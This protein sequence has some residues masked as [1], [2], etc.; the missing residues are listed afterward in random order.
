[1]SRAS[2]AGS[3]RWPLAALAL[4]QVGAGLPSAGYAY[5]RHRHDLA[6]AAVTALFAVLILNVMLTLWLCRLPGVDSRRAPVLTVALLATVG[7]DLLFVQDGRYLELVLASALQGCAVGAF[8]G[9]TPGVVGSVVADGDQASSRVIIANASGLAAGPVL[10]GAVNQLLPMPYALVYLAHAAGCLALAV[11]ISRIPQGI[12]PAGRS[13]R[14]PDEP[15]QRQRIA[16]LRG[17]LAFAMGGLISSLTAVLLRDGFGLESNFLVGLLIAAF[18][19]ANALIGGLVIARLAS[20]AQLV[21][22]VLIALGLGLAAGALHQ[23]NLPVMIVAIVV[24]G[25]GQ[26]ALIGAGILLAA[27]ADAMVGGNAAV[28]AFFFW[29][30]AGAATAAVVVGWASSATTARQAFLLVMGAIVAGVIAIGLCDSGRR[31]P[32]G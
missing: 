9:L 18:F 8:C 32:D 11:P 3:A 17:F 12:A 24:L 6:D 2:R 19:T 23:Q 22:T 26:G 20:R 28:A 21:G 10:A 14:S 31:Q 7:A 4:T 30:Y 29:C 13:W 16:E 1:M 25:G 27:R 15:R 5:Y